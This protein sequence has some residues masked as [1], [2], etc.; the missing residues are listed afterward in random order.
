MAHIGTSGW[1]YPH[2]DGV[3]Y[4]PGTPASAR[5]GLYARQ[6]STVEL[7]ASFY[8]WPRESGVRLVAPAAS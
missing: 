3:L 6:F 7:N 8:R 4:E 1:S 2:W 5:L